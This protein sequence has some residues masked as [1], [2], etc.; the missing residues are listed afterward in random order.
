MKKVF[1][2]TQNVKN[3]INMMNNLQNRA[4]GV[5]GMALVYGEPGLGKTQA[6]LW[7][8]TQNDA[9]F[10]RAA[11]QMSARW[12]M[13][14]IVEELGEVPYY[15]SSD[16]FKQCVRQLNSDPRVI[17]VDEIDYLTGNESAIETLRDIYDKTNTC[18]V[19]AGMGMAD[20]KLMRYR[21]LYDRISEKLKFTPFNKEDVM[22]I[23]Q[24]LSEVEITECAAKYIFSQTNRFRQIVKLINK[25]EQIAKDN[26]LSTIDEIT[27]KEFI[28]DDKSEIDKTCEKT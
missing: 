24:Q 25:A 9:I 13:Q 5:P 1:A 7:W 17:I 27:L 19:M 12:L 20:K 6:L 8:A 22:A 26:G 4:E 21:H 28:A 11:N 16:L 23:I 15:Y 2:R 3:F 18:I 10:I 14:E